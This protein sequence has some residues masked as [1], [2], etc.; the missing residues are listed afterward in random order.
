MG[1]GFAVTLLAFPH[2][3]A[4]RLERIYERCRAFHRAWLE[5]QDDPGPAVRAQL[6]ALRETALLEDARAL[7]QRLEDSDD[8]NARSVLHDVRG[9]ALSALIA[10]VRAAPPE[11]PAGDL[12]WWAQLA[13]DHAK[14]MRQAIVDLDRPTRSADEQEKKHHIGPI[15]AKW[16]RRRYSVDGRTV[17]VEVDCRFDGFL[18]RRCLESA[19]VDRVLYNLVNNATRFS[20]DGRVTLHIFP[21]GEGDVRFVV[22]NALDLEQAAWLDEHTERKLGRLFEGGITRGGHG[23]GLSNCAA[24][25]AAAYGQTPDT[26]VERGHIGATIRS[27]RFLAWFHWP[28]VDES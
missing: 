26:A 20:D 5:E 11:P 19:T 8:P 24:L 1:E 25:V 3:D 16:D 6:G 23:V 15:A 10:E 14:M 4:K 7:G 27:G 28:A 2:E 17:A 22:A 18:T 9:G 12:G 13:R 21:V